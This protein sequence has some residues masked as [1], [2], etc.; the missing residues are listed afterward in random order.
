MNI[1]IRAHYWPATPDLREIRLLIDGR[2]IESSF[3]SQ[4]EIWKLAKKFREYDEMLMDIGNSIE[5]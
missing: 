5:Y 3:M 2:I 4:D 1:E